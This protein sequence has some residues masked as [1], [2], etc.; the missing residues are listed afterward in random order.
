[1]A[2]LQR[3]KSTIYGLVTDLALLQQNIDAEATTR[4]D[5]DTVLQTNIDTEATTRGDADTALGVRIDNVNSGTGL[6]GD[7][8][9]APSGSNYLDSTSTLAGADLALDSAIKTQADAIAAE[10]TRATAAETANADAI[11]QEITDRADGDTAARAYA[12]GILQAFI[13]GDFA[14]LD[15]LVETVNGDS[16]TEG[17]F[18]KAIADVVA[19]AP[20]ALDTLNEIATYINVDG[21]GDDVLTAITN[22]ITAAKDELKGDVTAAYDTLAEIEDALD[23]VN[24]DAST[25]GSIAKTA[26]DAAAALADETTAREAADTTLTDNLAAEVTR[27]TDAE[28]TLQDNIDA[29]ETARIAADS[30]LS[31]GLANLSGVT[32]APTARSNIGVYSVAETDALLTSGASRFI[33]EILTVSSDQVTL[34]HEPRDGVILNFAT[35]RHTDANYV[36]YDVPVTVDVAGPKVFNLHPNASG[37]FDGLNVVV[38]YPYQET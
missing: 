23:I 5:A 18:R 12:D 31:S 2:I 37:D 9:V 11:A 13:D 21:S 28:T 27:A 4:G 35:V 1:M 24:G 22:S 34:T 32:D 7:A 19:S 33:T 8:Y 14:T 25:E 20:E 16:T 17:S 10:I 36:S 26:A 3:H 15:S 30:T 29:E 38:Q 6:V